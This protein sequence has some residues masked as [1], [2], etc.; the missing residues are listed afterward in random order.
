MAFV[1][2]AVGASGVDTTY[3]IQIVGIDGQ[4]L[5]D[6]ELPAP[7]GFGVFDLDWSPDSTRIAFSR[8]AEGVVDEELDIFFIGADGTGE[9]NLTPVSPEHDDHPRWSPDGTQIYF[10]SAR[11]GNREI[12]RINADG[13][14]PQNLTN[15]PAD[16]TTPELASCL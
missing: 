10:H 4:D 15:S 12:Y 11:D 1:R 5:E 9:Q 7:R 2:G 6:L 16:D 13:S 8:L 3:R 14:D